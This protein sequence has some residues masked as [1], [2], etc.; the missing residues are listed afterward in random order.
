MS[1]W[2]SVED[3]RLPVRTFTTGQGW[4]AQTYVLVV[5]NKGR[6]AVAWFTDHSCGKP[7]VVSGKAIG[8]VTHWMPLPDPPEFA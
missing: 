7:Q 4:S 1:E 5:D 2:I 8:A 6:M 3:R